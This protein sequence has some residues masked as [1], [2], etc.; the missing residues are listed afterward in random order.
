MQKP[1]RAD[2]RDLTVPRYRNCFPSAKRQ[3][4][5]GER[6]KAIGYFFL[7]AAAT[8]ITTPNSTPATGHTIQLRCQSFVI[9]L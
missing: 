2:R 7:T 4:A 3:T 1:I 5:S 9:K 6:L 8:A